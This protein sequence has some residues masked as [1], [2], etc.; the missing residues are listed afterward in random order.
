MT[1]YPPAAQAQNAVVDARARL[2]SI[3]NAIG[4]FIHEVPRLGQAP[5][6][7]S[8]LL[9]ERDRVAAELAGMGDSRITR[10]ACLEIFEDVTR[11]LAAIRAELLMMELAVRR[12]DLGIL[13]TAVLGHRNESA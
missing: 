3:D 2:Q 7:L 8:R 6:R 11:E 9:H 5:K 1:S 4:N 10:E 12:H 13:P